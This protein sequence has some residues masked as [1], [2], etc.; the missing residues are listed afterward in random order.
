VARANYILRAL[1]VPAGKHTIVFD[2]HPKSVAMTETVAYIAT[3]IFLL[4]LLG[5][6]VYTWHKRKKE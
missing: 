4:V 5:A 2:F 1:Q 3:A 6:G